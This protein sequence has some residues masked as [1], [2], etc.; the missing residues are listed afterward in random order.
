VTKV[1]FIL[2]RRA[3]FSAEMQSQIGLSTGL[4]NSAK[5]MDDMLRESGIDS[6]MSIVVDYNSIDREVHAH[7]PSHVIIEALWVT[8]NK[9]AELQRLHP[10]VIWIVRLH[11]NMP[12]LAGEGMALDWIGDYST[13]SR[14]VIAANSPRMLGELRI[15]LQIAARLTAQAVDRK[16]IL[17]ENYYPISYTDCSWTDKD[18]IHIGCFGAVRPMK[19]H[20]TQAVAALRYATDAGKILHFHIN[21]GRVEGKGEPVMRNLQ[22]MFEHVADAGHQLINH[23]W[24][25]HDQFLELCASMDV[26]MQ[27]SMSETFNIVAADMIDQ[28]VPVVLSREIPWSAEP[29]AA[30]PNDSS[31]IAAKLAAAAAEPSANVAWHQRNIARYSARSQQGWANYFNEETLT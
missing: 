26:G 3:D 21:M 5:F 9:L 23:S 7:R 27:V 11:S 17:L 14:V 12:F 28:G 30:D 25:P 6:H 22:S 15:Y 19:N 24:A 13:L 31:D 29:W 10:K 2:K 18:E 1:L 20:L 4:Y 8:P 16:V